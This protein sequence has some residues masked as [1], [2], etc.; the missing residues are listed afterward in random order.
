[1]LDVEWRLA[2]LE[3]LEKPTGID[4]KMCEFLSDVDRMARH[5]DKILQVLPMG[6]AHV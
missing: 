5:D 1:M 6:V 2:F 4:G 3:R